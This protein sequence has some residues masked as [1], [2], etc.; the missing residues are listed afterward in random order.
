MNI[1][2]LNL[3]TYPFR[4]RT[5]GQSTEIF[6]SIRKKFVVLTPE[7]WVRQHF[8]MFIR[9]KLNYPA[10][11]ISVERGFRINTRAK[12]TDVVVHD[13]GGS[14]WMIIE[15]KA[16]EVKLTEEAFYQ[17]AGYHI[18]LNALYLVVTN[19]MQ[20]Y[21]CKFADNSFEFIKDFP[22]YPF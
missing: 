11:M 19:G 3:P 4:T 18:K 15:C 2:Q 16:P 12:R 7:E 21:C 8:I 20:H 22:P 17:A 5:T 6:D 10:G 9:N 14:P 1:Q 13:T